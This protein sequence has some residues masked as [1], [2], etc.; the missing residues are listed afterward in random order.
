MTEEDVA[1]GKLL[2]EL[3]SSEIRNRIVN[4]EISFQST[5][6]SYTEARTSGTSSSTRT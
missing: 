3:D 1:E 2:V 5:L 6:A 4:Q